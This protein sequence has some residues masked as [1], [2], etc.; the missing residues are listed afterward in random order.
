M[1]NPGFVPWSHLRRL[2]GGQA[3]PPEVF[4]G[5]YTSGSLEGLRRPVAAL[6]G[7]R[8]ASRAG[9][10]LARRTARDLAAA[11]ITIVSGLALGIDTAAHEGALD[12]GGLTIGILGG[13]HEHFFPLSNRDLAARI[14]A[15]GGAV[16]S[17]Y[18]PEVEARPFRF[19]ERNGAVAALADAAVIVE[20]PE[21]SGS[22]NTAGWAAGRIP[23]LVFPGD[24]DRRAVAGCLALI[25]D[26]ATL[27][28]HSADIFEALGIAQAPV[29]QHLPLAN[30]ATPLHREIFDALERDALCADA[31]V[32]LTDASAAHVFSVLTEFEFDGIVERREGGVF[33]RRSA[34]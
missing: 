32:E 16:C 30:L 21:R 17:P 22:L 4:A 9:K 23:V 28:R 19:L 25:R 1:L 14:L 3:D 33:A 7:T 20:A 27:V 34:K 6:V 15:A 12:A 10:N 8:A 18:A 29:L 2:R 11:G 5:L 31:L 24:V 26:G 13:G